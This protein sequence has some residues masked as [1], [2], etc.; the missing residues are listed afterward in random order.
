MR[1]SSGYGH[2]PNDGRYGQPH[3]STPQPYHSQGYGPP[4]N[5]RD[6]YDRGGSR[7]PNK[8]K[9]R[10]HHPSEPP[11]EDRRRP[12]REPT[13]YLTCESLRVPVAFSPFVFCVCR[14]FSC[15]RVVD[16]GPLFHYHRPSRECPRIFNSCQRQQARCHDVC[17]RP[18]AVYAHGSK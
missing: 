11:K 9:S 15:E 7:T 16:D 2:G 14:C 8:G 10:E 1:Q 12:P 5:Q 17:G 3:H 6:H 4:S 13:K 18:P